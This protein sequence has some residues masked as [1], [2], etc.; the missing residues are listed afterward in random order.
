MLE[1]MFVGR[2][3]VSFDCEGY[4]QARGSRGA[5]ASQI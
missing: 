5:H 4:P 2:V 1:L 3:G